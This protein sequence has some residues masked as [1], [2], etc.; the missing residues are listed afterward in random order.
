V[1]RLTDLAPGFQVATKRVAPGVPTC[2]NYPGDRSDITFTGFA[3]SSFKLR[4]GEK[5]SGNSAGSS[6]GFFATPSQSELYWHKTVRLPY[7]KCLAALLSFG[8]GFKI[9][10]QR[11][12]MAKQIKIGPTGADKAVAYRLVALVKMPGKKAFVWTETAAFVKV[13]RTIGAIRVITQVS[14]GCGCQPDSHTQ[15][16]RLLTARLTAAVTR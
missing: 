5:V 12:M 13:G 15:L 2:A 6:A 14:P 3:N 16:A 10:P 11:M 8:P 9:K 4:I 1:I 7:I